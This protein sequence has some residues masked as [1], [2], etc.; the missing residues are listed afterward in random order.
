MRPSPF[1][2]SFSGRV[3]G[4]GARDGRRHVTDGSRAGEGNESGDVEDEAD[5]AVAQDGGAG[6][7]LDLPE[8]RFPALDHDLLLAEETVDDALGPAPL[9]LD[10]D[11]EALRCI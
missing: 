8:V 6:D 7:A 1:P 5:A 4:A 2:P 11:P 3:G 10:A 9:D